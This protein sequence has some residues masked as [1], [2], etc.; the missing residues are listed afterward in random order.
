[1]DD[2]PDATSSDETIVRAP[3][4][5]T[6][7]SPAQP[8][9][10]FL[11]AEMHRLL[12]F[13]EGASA[14]GGGFG[15]LDDDGRLQSEQPIETWVSTRM[16][17][18]FALGSLAGREGDADRVDHGLTALLHGGCLRDDVNEGWYSSARPAAGP[19]DRAPRPIG[20]RHQ[21]RVRPR[22]RRPGRIGGRRGRPP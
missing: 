8:S 17:Y 11:D 2:V 1:M 13:A 5:W 14:P 18:C 15:N 16:T 22:L 10:D 20:R 6:T 19:W 12:R 21:G 3:G 9:A 7:P 4:A